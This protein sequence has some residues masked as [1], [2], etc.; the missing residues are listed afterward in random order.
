MT[1]AASSGSSGTSLGVEIVNHNAAADK[2]MSAATGAPDANYGL[3]AAAAN[4]Q[5]AAARRRK[6]CCSS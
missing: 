5:Q 2:D 6:T 3:K 4:E 1:P